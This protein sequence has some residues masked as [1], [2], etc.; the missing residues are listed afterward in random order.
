MN[1]TLRLWH[2]AHLKEKKPQYKGSVTNVVFTKKKVFLMKIKKGGAIPIT[3]IKL[4][5]TD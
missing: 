4:E 3:A 2:I 5:C 1:E